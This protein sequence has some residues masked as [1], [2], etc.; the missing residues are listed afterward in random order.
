M[1]RGE[2]RDFFLPA[3]ASLH[4]MRSAVQLLVKKASDAAA[5][6]D[7][8]AAKILALSYP[9]LPHCTNPT[10]CTWKRFRIDFASISTLLHMLHRKGE[11]YESTTKMNSWTIAARRKEK[12]KM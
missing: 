3:C 1:N 10:L 2:V 8:S 12:R 6:C 9:S 7:R 11:N 4:S 5:Q